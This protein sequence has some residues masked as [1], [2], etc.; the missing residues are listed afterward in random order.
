MPGTSVSP[1][2]Q[3]RGAAGVPGHGVVIGQRDHVQPGRASLAHHLSGRAAAVRGRAV[4]VQIRSH[5]SRPCR[6]LPN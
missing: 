2:R 3:R 4:A 6:D 1:G 5:A